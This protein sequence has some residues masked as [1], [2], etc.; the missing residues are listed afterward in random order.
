MSCAGQRRVISFARASA[1]SADWRIVATTSSI[2]LTATAIVV[3]LLVGV[4]SDMR[5]GQ[6]VVLFENRVA[7]LVAFGSFLFALFGLLWSCADL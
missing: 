7:Y 3:M 6:E 5:L 2:L 1:A 4:N